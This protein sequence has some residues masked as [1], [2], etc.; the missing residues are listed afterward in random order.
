MAFRPSKRSRRPPESTE[1][2]LTPVMNL[3]VV[4]IPLLLTSAQFIRLGMIEINL[5]PAVGAGGTSIG[6]PKEVEK[7]L[8]LSVTITD[9]GFYLA[10]SLAVALGEKGEGPTIP[11]TPDGKYNYAELSRQLYE[12]KQKALGIFT[13]TNKIVILAAPDIDYQTVVS[14]MDA[15]RSIKIN[16]KIYSLFPVVSL[17]ATVI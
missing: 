4:L 10:S 14:T 15:T 11:K 13:D 3:M 2:K 9:T 6:V 17:G 16:G 7:K 8:D 12:I 5:P 1:L